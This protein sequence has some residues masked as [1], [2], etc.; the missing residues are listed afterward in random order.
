[1][2]KKKKQFNQLTM[3]ILRDYYQFSVDPK[4]QDLPW[5]S[6][7]AMKTKPKEPISIKVDMG[8]PPNSMPKWGK[9]GSLCPLQIRPIPLMHQALRKH[10]DKMGVKNIEYFKTKITNGKKFEDIPEFYAFN[11]TGFDEAESKFFINRADQIFI[12]S[13]L[14]DDALFKK[15]A[16]NV[17][18]PNTD[19]AAAGQ[20]FV[21]NFY[22]PTGSGTKARPTKTNKTWKV[23][24]WTTGKPLKKEPTKPLEFEADVF[25]GLMSQKS[26]LMLKSMAQ[27]LYDNGAK[28]LKFF[29]AIVKVAYPSSVYTCFVVFNIEGLIGDSVI[30]NTEK[31]GKP[32]DFLKLARFDEELEGIVIHKSLRDALLQAGFNANFIRPVH[33]EEARTQK[34]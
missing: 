30:L 10:L 22:G 24:D 4:M 6:G 19:Q 18:K 12:S 23:E 29:D 32:T 3:N 17:G 9:D 13:D 2:A 1:M 31:G 7:Q 11:V 26:P 5:H 34:E 14:V 33:W 20:F 15:L 21:L 27:F 28:N 25:P 16:L 8:P